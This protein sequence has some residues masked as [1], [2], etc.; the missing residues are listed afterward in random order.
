MLHLHVLSLLVSLI[1]TIKLQVD[2]KILELPKVRY[3]P[4]VAVNL[5]SYEL[6]EV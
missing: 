6:L 4:G 5:I 2:D 1:E 3:V